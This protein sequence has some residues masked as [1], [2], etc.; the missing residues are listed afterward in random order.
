MISKIT[1]WWR[2]FLERLAEANEKEF[3]NRPPSCC[4]QL[5]KRS[6]SVKHVSINKHRGK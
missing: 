6:E 4:S 5:P 1:K 3:Y 2:D